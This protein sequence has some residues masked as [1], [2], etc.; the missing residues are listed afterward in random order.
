[1][2]TLET[3]AA[4]VPEAL[5][6]VNLPGSVV[7]MAALSGRRTLSAAT[8]V[9]VRKRNHRQDQ[10]SRSDSDRPHGITSRDVF[11]IARD[12][13][14]RN[15]A[16]SNQKIV[17]DSPDICRVGITKSENNVKHEVPTLP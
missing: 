6:A 12:R 2:T 15:H 13:R 16:V 11:R 4:V 9:R 7:H 8:A 3:D 17:C 1:M 10:Y 14:D 5:V